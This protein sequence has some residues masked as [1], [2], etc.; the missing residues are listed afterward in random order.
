M[1]P[2]SISPISDGGLG[3]IMMRCLTALAVAFA[4]TVSAVSSAGA[5]D[6]VNVRL[7]ASAID[8]TDLGRGTWLDHDALSDSAGCGVCRHGVGGF[9]RRRG[10]RGQ[11]SSRCIRYRSHRSRTGD[12]ARS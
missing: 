2:L 4:V 9:I 5:V 10:G 3:S 6:A 8:L 1:H 7:D 12:L 11:R